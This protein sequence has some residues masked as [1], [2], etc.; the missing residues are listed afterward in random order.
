[1]LSIL[2]QSN[3][4]PNTWMHF[5]YAFYLQTQTT[6]MDTDDYDDK[7]IQNSDAQPS[8]SITNPTCQHT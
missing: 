5:S 3:S 6:A 2:K 7:V 1:M 4:Q 8:V